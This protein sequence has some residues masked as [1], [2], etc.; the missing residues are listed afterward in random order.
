MTLS[1]V[2]HRLVAGLQVAVLLATLVVVAP[3]AAVTDPGSADAHG[4]IIMWE[5]GAVHSAAAEQGMQRLGVLSGHTFLDGQATVIEAEP[6]EISGLIEELSAIPGVAS[7]EPDYPVS[8]AWE[9]NDP[10]YQSGAQWA[11]SRIQ[12]SRAWDVEQG[13]ASVLV[14]VVDTG[15]DLTHPDLSASLDKVNDRNFLL[16]FTDPGYYTAGDDNG[17]GTHVAG[18]VAACTDNGTGVAG[19]AP[20]VRI[21]PLKVMNS[22]G[23][24]DSS[25][26]AEAISYATDVG[27][28]VINLSLAL[29]YGDQSAAIQTAIQQAAAAGV[30]VVAASG[31][32]YS[33]SVRYPAAYPECIAVGAT[34]PTDA[35]VSYSNYG[36]A[37]DVVAPGGA[38][39]VA[40]EQI[41][42]TYPV[43]LSSG[44]GY[45]YMSGTSM[46]TPYVAGAVALLKSY[47]PAATSAEIRSAIEV[48]AKDVGDAEFDVYTGHGLLQLRNALDYLAGTDTTSPTTTSNIVAHYDDSA[49]I[50]FSAS[51]PGGLGVGAT[52]Y[53]VDSGTTQRASAFTLTGYGSRTVQYWSDDVVGNQE[54]PNS[55][56]L[57]IDDTCAPV[58]SSNAA[59]AY[60]STATVTLSASDGTGIGV[61]STRYSVDHAALVSDTKAVVTEM[62]EHTLSYGSVDKLGNKE[63][64]KTVSFTV[65]GVPDV[66]RVS[67]SNRYA[68]AASLS[69][70]TFSA[71]AE[72]TAI[73]ASGAD[74]ADALSAS[75]LAGAMDAP[76]LLTAKSYLP[77]ETSAELTRLGVKRV[78]IIGGTAAVS[79]TVK[80]ALQSKGISVERIQGV[81]R[82][83]TAATVAARVAEE[84]G[85]DPLPVAFV[86]RGDA[87]ADALAVSSLA[88]SQGYP[89]LLT[90][91]TSLSSATKS[92]L[93]DL[94]VDE[95]VIAGGTAAVSTAV[96]SA[97]EA[98]PDVTVTRRWGETRYETAASVV[99]Y[100]LTRGWVSPAFVG[101]AT[102]ADFP[103]ALG[104]GVTAARNDGVLVLSEP[105]KLSSPTSTVIVKYGSDHLPIWVYGGTSAVS[106]TVQYALQAL[107]F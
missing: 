52:Y 8:I 71:G 61:E 95:V 100:G 23:G 65:R 43:S 96:K 92:A 27:A 63:T 88:A 60:D 69:A 82:Y 49:S 36:S 12:A 48:S 14:A 24:G 53:K 107:R 31:N 66:S 90:K 46:A 78:I 70:L 86:V 13:D 26:V 102:G 89:V 73:I 17:H 41:L 97:I 58:T 91:T 54:T 59:S 68:T 81:D 19:T 64:T 51:D 80:S 3:A 29:G 93:L 4:V 2:T 10:Y 5:D 76:L 83:A 30:V 106:S 85:S 104:G 1:R 37:L 74:F 50:T 15:A 62:G 9:P 33:S 34:G 84:R 39:T 77:S 22:T 44:V 21:L 16:S 67:G 25:D 72:S 11:Y 57:F 38:V 103:D 42:S 87:F 56:T 18:I 45:G 101:V 6:E 79:T 98:L 75:G 28:D 40:D 32:D 105:L 47:D 7:V 99:E 94:G 20:G 55:E 35:R